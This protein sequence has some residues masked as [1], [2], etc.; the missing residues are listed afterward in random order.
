[1]TIPLI[2]ALGLLVALALLAIAYGQVRRLE[3]EVRHIRA[4]G[5][6]LCLMQIREAV[7]AFHDAA[8][9]TVLAQKWD[10]PEEQTNL[11]VLAR[12]KYVPGGPSMPALWLREQAR[13][14]IERIDT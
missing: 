10:S 14:T 8:L 11:R 12:E 5:H 7:G 9:L 6:A 13:A 2:L 3:H 4:R 1:M